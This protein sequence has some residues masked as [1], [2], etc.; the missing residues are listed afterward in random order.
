VPVGVAPAYCTTEEW[1]NFTYIIKMIINDMQTIINNPYRITGVLVGTTAKEQSRQIKHLKQYLEVEQEPP[2]DFSFPVFGPLFRTVD[3]VTEAASKLNLDSDKMNAALFWFYKG[4]EIIDEAAF[5]A[6]KDGDTK[7]AVQIWEKLIIDV[8]EDGKRYWKE[9]TN[10][11]H[12][13]FHNWFVIEFL[14]KNYRS[15]TANLK[16]LESDYYLELKKRAT[17]E[18]FKITKKDLQ[19][20]FL[21][22][23][24]D[25]I[26]KKNINLSWNELINHIKNENFAAKQDFLKVIAQKFTTGISAQIE[27]ARKQRSANN[28]NAA[29]AGD[30]LYN[31]TKNDIEELKSIVGVESLSYSSIVDKLANE[32]LQCGIDYFNH[33]KDSNTDHGMTLMNLFQ[34]AKSLAMGNITKQRCDENIEGLEEWQQHTKIKP[35]IDNLLQTMQSFEIKSKTVF[36]AQKLINQ[37]RQDLINIKAILGGTDNIYIGV[38]TQIAIQAQQYV[39]EEVNNS[40]ESIRFNDLSPLKNMLKEAWKVTQQIETLDMESTYWIHHKK[41]KDALKNI[42]NQ[43]SVP[44]TVYSFSKIPQLDFIIIDSEIMSIDKNYKSLLTTNPLYKKYV[45]YVGLNLKVEVLRKQ[46]VTIYKKY[47]KPDGNIKRNS[48]SSPAGYTSSKTIDIDSNMKNIDL[49]GWGN[50]DKCIYELGKHSIEVWID[51]CMV[52]KKEFV[53]DLAPSEKLEIDLR[54]AEKR[55]EEIKRTE[56]YVSEINAANSK[57]QKIQEFQW[58]RSSTTRSMQISEQEKKIAKLKKNAE[59]EKKMQIYLQQNVIDKLKTDIKNV[60]Y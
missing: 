41:N 51:N 46:T 29:K 52:H 5:E 54:K 2:A 59:R 45:R 12:S 37:T 28:A 6:L 48:K 40:Q 47:I 13:A 7:Q 27:T 10:K 55:L 43:L 60:K 25:E 4:N 30:N 1:E 22:I 9:V 11:N 19:L 56:Y 33:Y 3:S 17:D 53:I 57:M 36:N 31:Q 26:E 23:I 32:I 38:S 39:I 8:K 42:C 21:N 50:A 20:N 15:I 58:F 16:F 24:A 35:Y 44:I 49:S 34:T 14:K 18:T